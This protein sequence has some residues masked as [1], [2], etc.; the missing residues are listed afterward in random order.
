[1]S[2][3][4]NDSSESADALLTEG[5]GGSSGKRVLL[6][7]KKKIR[8]KQSLVQEEFLDA[9]SEEDDA[10]IKEDKVKN[11]KKNNKQED[12]GDEEEDKNDSETEEETTIRRSTT[13]N[14]SFLVKE[15]DLKAKRA[16]QLTSTC[17][18]TVSG[19]I[20]E[21]TFI[22]QIFGLTKIQSLLKQT[23]GELN[24]LE[25]SISKFSTPPSLPKRTSHPAIGALP[26]LLSAVSS[27]SSSSG[28]KFS[29]AQNSP[30][31]KSFSSSP[32]FASCTST[33]TVSTMG[34]ELKKSNELRKAALINASPRAKTPSPS[35]SP[36]IEQFNSAPPSSQLATGTSIN[37]TPPRGSPSSPASTAGSANSSPRTP[38]SPRSGCESL[39]DS[40][41][42][43]VLYASPRRL[44]LS[45]VEIESPRLIG[46]GGSARVYQVRISPGF[47]LAA[48][49]Y[50]QLFLPDDV[51]DQERRRMQL[52]LDALYSL[53]SHPHILAVLAYRFEENKLIVLMEQM[54]CSLRDIIDKRREEKL[55]ETLT[56][57]NKE[58]EVGKEETRVLDEKDGDE[59]G[60]VEGEEGKEKNN[61]E[62]FEI[63]PDKKRNKKKEKRKRVVASVKTPIFAILEVLGLYK[64][65]VKA[66]KFLHNVPACRE[67][68]SGGNIVG[69]IHRDIKA[70]NVACVR[71]GV[72]WNTLLNDIP[73]VQ[74]KKGAHEEWRLALGDF[75]ECHIKYDDTNP[76]SP[77]VYQEAS[78]ELI[79]AF[80]SI[81]TIAS[82]SASSSTS[83][84][85][86]HSLT[87]PSS[88]SFS[89]RQMQT[90]T[91]ALRSSEKDNS[92]KSKVEN[93]KFPKIA[94]MPSM[95]QIFAAIG[96]TANT[97]EKVLEKVAEKEKERTSGSH[98]NMDRTSAS[99]SET[100]ATLVKTTSGRR[101]GRSGF[102]RLSLNVGTLQFMSPEMLN[103][104]TTHYDESVDIW[105]CGMVLFELLTG[106]LPYA[107]DNWTNFQLY[108]IIRR[109][110]RPTLPAGYL[111]AAE[112]KMLKKELLEGKGET[113]AED[114]GGSGRTDLDVH[115]DVW[116]DV[117]QIYFDCTQINPS[118]RPTAAQL[119]ERIEKLETRIKI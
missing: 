51:R 20:H 49:V 50:H 2:S 14:Q 92:E 90:N 112:A 100:G 24:A 56:T 116:C 9:L 15:C 76:C 18:A 81:N 114:E 41:R 37:K 34:S 97:A 96:G 72:A 60:S 109:G 31:S 32:S 93:G 45:T 78:E 99:A 89:S 107:F 101:K 68:V 54:D 69:C 71:V 98:V 84:S 103:K 27:A 52:K 70:E 40:P 83:E 117:L 22:E 77:I 67:I 73:T 102:E 3:R 87:L 74:K 28:S 95:N 29:S 115:V 12:A 25:A 47:V 104:R 59:A 57:E 94:S 42:R 35:S 75:D 36:R 62:T 61:G 53:P 118:R 7:M 88:S 33:S 23:V 6:R 82:S 26:S 13:T 91:N 55:A 66:A 4:S 113:G 105:S 79:A 39:Q 106:E 85:L 108:D 1:M 16:K 5:S 17:I 11:E 65:I 119:L 30:N 64:Q 43:F 58:K 46:C 38:L 19:L 21:N 48:K 44:N 111:R 110:L 86:A 8:R 10:K 80:T 63:V